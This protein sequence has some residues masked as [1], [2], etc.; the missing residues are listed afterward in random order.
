V[1]Y[2]FKG[3]ALE[4]IKDLAMAYQKAVAGPSAT[5]QI[6]MRQNVLDYHLAQESYADYL[7]YV[8]PVDLGR[9]D[10]E[11]CRTHPQ[12]FIWPSDRFFIHNRP[13]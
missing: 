5:S 2:G 9:E 8:C 3:T 6:E 4:E 12:Y 10:A 11:L 13:Q 7:Q 1:S